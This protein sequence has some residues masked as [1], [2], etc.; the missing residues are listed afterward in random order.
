MIKGDEFYDNSSMK[1]SDFSIEHHIWSEIVQVC[2]IF[3][4][5]TL[6]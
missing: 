5:P 2:K 4:I 1:E 6:Q 3:T